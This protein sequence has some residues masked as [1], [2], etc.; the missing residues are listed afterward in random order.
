MPPLPPADRLSPEAADRRRQLMQIGRACFE[1]DG[2][3]GTR[4]STI[5]QRA[6]VAQGT[7]YRY[8]ESKEHL[9]AELRRELFG[10][11]LDAFRAA[12]DHPGPADERLV[13]VAVAL[14]AEVHGSRSL[15]Q[16]FRQAAT[17]EETERALIRSRD[18]MAE[19]LAALLR[20]GRAEGCLEV[21]D[22]TLTAHLVLSLFDDLVYHALTYASPGAP[23]RVE[24][25]GLAFL[26]RALRVPEARVQE[27]LLHARPLLPPLAPEPS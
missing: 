14:F 5:V 17:G 12:A 2:Y 6:G 16:V 4:V 21:G 27:L 11:Y 18:R 26:L 7:F 13:H 15:I 10:Q 1:A 20:A 8:F 23:D 3:A 22:P 24:A 9:L 19:P 25:E